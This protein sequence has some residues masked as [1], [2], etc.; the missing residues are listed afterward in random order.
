MSNS[1]KADSGAD[2]ILCSAAVTVHKGYIVLL[3]TDIGDF[4]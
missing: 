2:F 3:H 1:G 4:V